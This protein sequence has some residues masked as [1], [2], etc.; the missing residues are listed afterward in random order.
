MKTVD[1]SSH[2]KIAEAV[3]WLASTPR[4]QRGPAIVELQGRFGLSPAEACNVCRDLYR[5]R[6][7]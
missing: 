2:D 1:Q 4:D 6:S 5:A 7:I 3:K